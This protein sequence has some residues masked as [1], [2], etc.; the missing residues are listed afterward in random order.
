M[1]R[2]ISYSNRTDCMSVYWLFGCILYMWVCVDVC[3]LT[4][5]DVGVWIWVCY[6]GVWMSVCGCGWV[7]VSVWI[8]VC[9]CG[10]GWV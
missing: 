7:Y 10:R 1:V 3:M 6:M 5:V 9:E 4:C 2:I 8:W